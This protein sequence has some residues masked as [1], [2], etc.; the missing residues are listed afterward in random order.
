MAN[1]SEDITTTTTTT[2]HFAHKKT[3]LIPINHKKYIESK[4]YSIE[5]TQK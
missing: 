1:V 3:T 4:F 2:N 5:V